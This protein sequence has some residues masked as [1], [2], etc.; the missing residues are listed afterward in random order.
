M[1]LL[2][3]KLFGLRAMATLTAL[4]LVSGGLAGLV[5]GPT[6]VAGA[7]LQP[8]TQVAAGP[9]NPSA[10]AVDAAGDLFIADSND[11]TVIVVPKTSGTIFG[12]AVTANVPAKLNA[13]TGLNDPNSLAFDAAGNLYITNWT[14]ESVVVV[15]VSTGTLYGH[16]VTADTATT[17]VT[18]EGRPAQVAFY[19]G[20][21]LVANRGLTASD[22]PGSIIV[23]PA[24]TG[25]IYGQS[26]TAGTQTTLT[27][28]TGLSV[29]NGVAVDGNGNLF[30][31]D[32][33]PDTNGGYV[34]VLP[35]STSTIF[36]QSFTANTA[37]TLTTATN[38]YG[39]EELS[40]DGSGNLFIAETGTGGVEGQVLVVSSGTS[41]FGQSVTA[42]TLAG[43]TATE[44]LNPPNGVA[45]DGSGNLYIATN[46]GH[47]LD[48][49]PAT[50]GT[51]FGQS[52]TADTPS[53]L[54][55][56]DEVIQPGALAVDAAGDLFIA[57]F[58]G[59]SVSVI[60]NSTGTFFGQTVTSGVPTVLTATTGLANSPISIAVNSTGDLF[61][62]ESSPD[63][64][65][66]T[67]VVAPTSGTIFGQSVV[68]DTVTALPASS[69][70]DPTGLAVD[71]NG[72]LFITGGEGSLS[73]L[74]AS[75]DSIFGE[76]QT[77][78]TLS[79]LVSSGLNDPT[80]LAFDAEGN[81]F[82]ANKGDNDI[83]VLPATTGSLFG[84]SVTANTS[85]TL[86]AA[87][88]LNGPSEV[89]VSGS[90]NLFIA[91]TN[92]SQEVVLPATTGTLFG[93]SVTANTPVALSAFASLVGPTGVAVS[94]NDLYA[95]ENS[96]VYELLG[97][98]TLTQ[99]SPTS[100]TVANDDG[101]AGGLSVNNAEGTVSYVET[102]ST[103][104]S[105]IAVDSSGDITYVAST[106]AAG[107]YTVT[108]SDSDTNTPAGSG[109]WTFTLSVSPPA[110]LQGS[111]TSATVANDDG[112]S[113]SLSV[114][115]GVG[116]V[117]YVETSSTYS[118]DIAV[119]SAGA[120]TYTASALP[121]GEY[122]V[123]GSDSDGDTPAAS[124]AW[125]FT[126]TVSAPATPPSSSGGAASPTSSAAPPP[127]SAT[128]PAS[129][130][131]TPT[132]TT[133][134]STIST[135]VTASSGNA[136]E[137]V[138]APAGALPNG[139]S[140]SIYPVLNSASL[141]GQVPSGS[142]YR[143]LVWR[144][145]GNID[146]HCT[147]RCDADHGNHH[148]PEH[149]GGRHC[150]RRYADRVGGRGHRVRERNDHLHLFERSHVRDRSVRPAP[151]RLPARRS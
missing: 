39:P 79:T 108:G 107:I 49:I 36:G 114:T 126:L 53:S 12:Q 57:N 69:L 132:T 100:A 5:A 94:G 138:T 117:S 135:T 127:T 103:Y 50:T 43:L 34:T 45:F 24:T 10:V 149:C 123:S 147:D 55:L 84:Q 25:T 60:A 52:V 66:D 141:V 78:N 26:V 110:L 51:L 23:L 6:Q 104:S 134:S 133:A 58:A 120:I 148:G 130:F 102:S 29:P 46:S 2:S 90:G 20:D 56:V 105:D 37:A 101:Y 65:E 40:F 80:A 27:N 67:E 21:L 111:P 47:V 115:N 129:A 7:D 140:L 142:S 42:D 28:A 75:S 16:S 137:T 91:N 8:A 136:S 64:T 14:G 87:S 106:L 92:D 86:T 96:S 9:D 3:P 116:T 122:T 30:I 61:I 17:L 73:V 4:L 38:L 22:I 63:G 68:A 41:V 89:A 118:S 85:V 11:N 144:V 99:S 128:V 146:G 113:G 32:A 151:P 98:A 150:L 35:A 1:K 33:T 131:G 18:M 77:E 71:S 143:A 81:L 76:A 95:T 82:V 83:T 13:V 15:P 93:Q 59:N 119:D 70:Y 48:V 88:G 44:S 112:Y 97:G 121:T 109:A 139:T 125:S 62:E 124:G 145:L 19:D 54:V 31:S 74:P 72:D